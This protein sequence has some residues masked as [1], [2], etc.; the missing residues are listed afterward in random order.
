MLKYLYSLVSTQ[1]ETFTIST[2]IYKHLS[3]EQKHK[4]HK[5]YNLRIIV[6]PN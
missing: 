6:K 5:K 4:L 3:K 2:E 1:K